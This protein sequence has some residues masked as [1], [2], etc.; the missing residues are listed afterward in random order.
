[1]FLL[2]DRTGRLGTKWW[3]MV[4]TMWQCSWSIPSNFFDNIPSLL[5]IKLPISSVAV[6]GTE[7]YWKFIL[8]SNCEIVRL[9]FIWDKVKSISICFLYDTF[10][11]DRWQKYWR[12]LSVQVS[13]LLEMEL[14][15]VSYLFLFCVFISGMNTWSIT[16][17]AFYPSLSPLMTW[18]WR[19]TTCWRW[20]GWEL[21]L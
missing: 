17:V 11:T 10:S 18:P 14:A 8:S 3:P 4:S 15:W 16:T 21:S 13:L 5:I 9:A 12:D 20:R 7:A 6:H 19:S 1:M 2:L